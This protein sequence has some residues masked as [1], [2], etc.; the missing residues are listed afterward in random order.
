MH[1]VIAVIEHIV[2]VFDFAS[3]VLAGLLAGVML[4]VCF[5][6][7]PRGLDA[8]TYVTQQQWGVRTL[9]PKVPPLGI[10]TVV[11]TLVAALLPRSDAMH[12]LLLYVATGLVIAAGLITKLLNMPVNAVVMRWSPDEPP[13]EWTSL[14]DSWWRW[15]ILRL[16]AGAL[17]F[18]VL[19]VAALR[20]PACQI[21]GNIGFKINLIPLA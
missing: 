19:V 8:S 3:L 2:F 5:V 18:G 20:Q 11:T 14:R 9:H 1:E 21:C 12:T 6:F 15:H 16:T 17:G 4:A 7:N 13:A 10:A